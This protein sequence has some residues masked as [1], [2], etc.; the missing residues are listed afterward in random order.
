MKKIND[1][2]NEVYEYLKNYISENS[3]PPSVREISAALKINST[4]TVFYYL[5]KLE[6]RGKIIRSSNKNRAITLT[7]DNISSEQIQNV[8]LVGSVCAGNGILAVENIE[9]YY[10][11]PTD[12]FKGELFLLRVEG[13]SMTGADIKEG[14]LLVVRKQNCADNG[15]IVVALL[16]DVATVKRLVIDRSGIYLHP[17]ND[18]YDDIRFEQISNVNIQGV[19]VGSIKKF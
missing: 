7:S 14:D 9:G 13:D 4:S 1:K 2:L 3:F 19:V 15:K 16:D 6:E 10:P 18:S 5:E 12:V 17:E 8:P 11:L